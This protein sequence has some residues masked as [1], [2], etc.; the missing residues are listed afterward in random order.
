MNV[1]Q[2]YERDF[3][4]WAMKMAHALKARD[5]E[6]LDFDHLSEELEDMGVSQEREMESRLTVL[7]MH[8]LKWEHQPTYQSKSW[9]LTIKEQRR[10]IARRLKKTPSLKA[11][12]EEMLDDV[13]GDAI[14]A[15]Q[16]ETGLAESEFPACLPYTLAQL[17]DDEFYP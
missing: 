5:I 2:L 15:A 7:I 3:Y 17:L 11:K 6:Q 8:L 10:K 12:I 16:K 1:S 14:L 9:S 13:Y 4:A